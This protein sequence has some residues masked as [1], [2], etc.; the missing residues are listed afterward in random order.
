MIEQDIPTYSARKRRVLALN[1]VQLESD[2]V[3]I[4]Y[5]MLSGK[6]RYLLYWQ[7]VKGI[8]IK[9]LNELEYEEL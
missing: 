5:F 9:K 4:R 2:L 8:Y 3:D 1:K 7:V 6:A